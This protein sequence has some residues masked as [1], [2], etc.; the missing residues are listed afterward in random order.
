MMLNKKSPSKYT[1]LF[2]FIMI[3]ANLLTYRTFKDVVFSKDTATLLYI[4]VYVYTLIYI[5]LMFYMF[6]WMGYVASYFSGTVLGDFDEKIGDYMKESFANAVFVLPIYLIIVLLSFSLN[7][8]IM[9]N[10]QKKYSP[11]FQIFSFVIVFVGFILSFSMKSTDKMEDKDLIRF[12]LI[13]ITMMGTLQSAL[14]TNT[15][16]MNTG[17]IDKM[18]NS[19]VN[20]VLNF[21]WNIVLIFIPFLLV[22]VG[23]MSMVVNPVNVGIVVG[24][25]IIIIL[26]FFLVRDKAKKALKNFQKQITDN[27]LL[28][29]TLSW[30]LAVL[31][32]STPL[33][34]ASYMMTGDVSKLTTVMVEIFN[35][36]FLIILSVMRMI[37]YSLQ[38]FVIISDDKIKIIF[39]M[40]IILGLQ[41]SKNKIK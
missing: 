22:L 6:K 24:S 37:L 39:N 5:M 2:V 31:F 7:V 40:M 16:S 17:A 4:V 32:Y 21:N 28:K 13:A 10:S 29:A 33:F 26:G 11:Y 3:L 8:N 18:I 34:A 36:K 9:Y 35:K 14:P 19:F 25:L 12:M 20:S 1:V 30:T 15:S 41:V 23:A 38:K 27:V